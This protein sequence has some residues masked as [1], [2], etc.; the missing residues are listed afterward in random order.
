MPGVLPAARAARGVRGLE[1]YVPGMPVEELE[2]LHGV[3]DAI[4]LA[5]NENPLGPSPRA[6]A[7]IAQALPEVNRWMASSRALSR[8]ASSKIAQATATGASGSSVRFVAADLSRR[9]GCRKGRSPSV[10]PIGC[11]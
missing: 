9:D 2:R 3:R 10:D 6:L 5:S 1:P 7:A 8:W 11:S 4:K